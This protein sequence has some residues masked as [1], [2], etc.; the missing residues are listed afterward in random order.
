VSALD[1]WGLDTVRRLLGSVPDP[2][3]FTDLPG[4][5]RC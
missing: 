3:P 4:P 5:Y 1:E 2:A